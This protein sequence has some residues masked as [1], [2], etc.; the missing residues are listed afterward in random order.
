MKAPL[1]AALTIAFGAS[2]AH[3]VDLAFVAPIE[4]SVSWFDMADCGDF[5]GLSSA[6]E[7]V[8]MTIHGTLSFDLA[9][10]R[11]VFG[12]P[13][14]AASPFWLF[15]GLALLS[16]RTHDNPPTYHA[17]IT[18]IGGAGYVD[19]LIDF[20]PWA[21]YADVAVRLSL[22]TVA[23]PVPEPAPLALL[24]FGLLAIGGYVRR[25]T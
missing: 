25:Q 4:H 6:P 1:L 24:G 23:A 10:A 20:E 19:L 3:A 18:G 9:A 14:R 16:D 13:M 15:D 2:S 17:S 5:P 22:D 8:N 12:S 7:N 11:G 21:D